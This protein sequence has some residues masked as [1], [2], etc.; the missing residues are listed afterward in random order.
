MSGAWAGS[1]E[2]YVRAMMRVDCSERPATKPPLNFTLSMCG[3]VGDIQ[4]SRG[5]R[6]EGLKEF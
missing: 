6:N 1:S 2:L 5:F 3:P 4:G